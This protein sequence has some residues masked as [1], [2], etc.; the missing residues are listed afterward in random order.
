MKILKISTSIFLHI[1]GILLIVFAF[2]P[3]AEWYYNHRPILGI[4][5]FHTVTFVRY[6]VKFYEFIPRNFFYYNYGGYP[7]FDIVIHNLFIPI[8]FLAKFLPL[9]NAVKISAMSSLLILLIFVYFT[10]IRH[11]KSKR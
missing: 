5:F 11:F 8:S 4:D 3:I 1:A 6:L 10:I 9:I 2:R 7:F